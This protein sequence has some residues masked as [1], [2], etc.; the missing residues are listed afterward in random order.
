MVLL[1]P[2]IVLFHSL[3]VNSSQ[4]K[5]QTLVNAQMAPKVLV[6]Q[7]VP[8]TLVEVVVLFTLLVTNILQV[9]RIQ[10]MLQTQIRK[11]LV[12]Y[13]LIHA[14]SQ[15]TTLVHLPQHL[16]MVQVMKFY[17]VVGSRG[18]HF[19]T[20]LIIMIQN[21]QFLVFHVFTKTKKQSMLLLPKINN[22]KR[23]T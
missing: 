6:I 3:T 14:V 10:V 16:V 19:M 21:A 2:L 5:P 15:I 8:T 12:N 17:L 7:I 20:R 13:I 23:I 4:T 9:T 1:H 11:S 22:S 18:L